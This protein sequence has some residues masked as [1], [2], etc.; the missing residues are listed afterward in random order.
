MGILGIKW[1]PKHLERGELQSEVFMTL[2]MSWSLYVDK[3]EPFVGSIGT[4]EDKMAFYVKVHC[5]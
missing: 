4:G 2:R 5:S 3:L 1:S